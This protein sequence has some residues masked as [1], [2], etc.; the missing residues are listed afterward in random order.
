MKKLIS[1]LLCLMMVVSMASFVGAEAVQTETAEIVWDENQETILL[2]HGATYGEGAK[3]FVF[4]VSCMGQCDVVC[5]NTDAA[6]VGEALAE[7]NI[8]AGEESDWGLYVKTINGITADYNTDGT[9]WAFYIDGE[10][11]STGVDATEINEESIY[12]MNVDGLTLEEGTTISLVD[13]K[14]YGFGDKVFAFQVMTD[15]ENVIT[16]SVSTTAE[17]VGAALSELGIIA[18]EESEWGLYVKT[19]NNVTADYNV[20]G[21]YWAFYIDGEYASTGVDA[22]EITDGAVYTFAVEG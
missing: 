19:I 21:K 4:A 2:Q 7:L 8:I 15:E 16:V 22:T 17:T 11:A 18:G 5:I 20:D 10:Y 1:L 14:N 13:G 12:L 6:T 9:Y 3:S